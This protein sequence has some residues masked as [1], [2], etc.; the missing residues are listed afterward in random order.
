MSAGGGQSSS[1]SQSTNE[2]LSVA[3][4]SSSSIGFNQ[5]YIDPEQQA[6]QQLLSGMAIG[7]IGQGAGI[8][9]QAIAANN[10]LVD[11]T[12]QIAAQEASLAT[13]LGNLFNNEINP[14]IE[15]QSL[16]TGG[17]GG[18]RQGVAQGVAAGQ[19]ADAYTTGLGD[20]TARAN[21]QAGN[22]I[23]MSSG[24]ANFTMDQ[25]AQAGQ[26]L[27]SPTVLQSGGTQSQSFN[28]AVSESF[29]QSSSSADSYDFSFGWV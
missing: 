23:N 29:G 17:F 22:A 28:Q 3:Q 13:G 9:D 11:P 21:S 10:A 26:I 14:A 16:S 2:A 7:Q 5:S 4:G 15:S 18:G 20:I 1:N 12:A 19:I 24:L 8:N 6:A 27:G 25:I